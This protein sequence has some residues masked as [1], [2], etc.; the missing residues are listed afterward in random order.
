MSDMS[1]PTY[2]LWAQA[3]KRI[4]EDLVTATPKPQP[5]SDPF[6]DELIEHVGRNISAARGWCAPSTPDYR[7]ED[8]DGS[9][10]V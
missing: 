10:A 5:Q 1:D 6:M 7:L 8:S 2:L 3:A 4:P 9:D